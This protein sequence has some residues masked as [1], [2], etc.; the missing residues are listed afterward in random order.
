MQHKIA[1]LGAYVVPDEADGCVW[2]A[3]PTSLPPIRAQTRRW[4]APLALDDDTEHD[5]VLAVNEAASNVIDHAYSTPGPTDL[6]AVKLWTEPDHLYV[7]VADHGRW[8]QPN[9]EP[10]YRGRGILLMQQV[11]ESVVIHHD[12]SGTRVLLRQTITR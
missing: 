8:R 6:V 1:H 5:V 2:A 7:E 12:Q 3:N 9:P 10:G 11:I 4:L